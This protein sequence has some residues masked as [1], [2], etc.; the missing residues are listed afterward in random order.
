MMTVEI[1]EPSSRFEDYGVKRSLLEQK[2]ER[3]EKRE[4]LQPGNQERTK[5]GEVRERKQVLYS[6]KRRHSNSNDACAS[7]CLQVNQAVISINVHH[8]LY[9]W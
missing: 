9:R 1:S 2:K 7:T 6:L 8:W 4:K 5:S 3:V